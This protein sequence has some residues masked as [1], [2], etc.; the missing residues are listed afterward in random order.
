M[1]D[2]PR[3]GERL[4]Y[5]M[6][7]DLLGR[8][9]AVNHSGGSFTTGEL[10]A[11]CDRPMGCVR[12]E[13]GRNRWFVLDTVKGWCAGNRQYIP[14]PP[15]P[16]SWTAG[17]GQIPCPC[18]EDHTSMCPHYDVEGNPKSE[19]ALAFASSEERGQ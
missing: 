13:D 5:A 14:D 6:A 16:Q 11:I 15:V 8:E 12:G 4:S 9:I 3:G 7:A 19:A 18:R 1:D 17:P 10:T 2:T